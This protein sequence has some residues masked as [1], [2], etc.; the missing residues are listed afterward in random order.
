MWFAI[1]NGVQAVKRIFSPEKKGQ[2]PCL[3]QA[4]RL[5][6]NLQKTSRVGIGKTDAPDWT[7]PGAQRVER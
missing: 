3:E 4:G 7:A 1:S 2:I 5:F 6:Y